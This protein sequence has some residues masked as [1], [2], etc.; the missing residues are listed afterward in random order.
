MRYQQKNK[1]KTAKKDSVDIN[2]RKKMGLTQAQFAALLNI[3]RAQLT[4]FES[5]KRSLDSAS[6]ALLADIQL[7]F[8]ELETGNL[9]AYR[10]L[11]TRLFL[12][13]EYKKA[14]PQMQALEKEF[15]QT[16]KE[17]KNDLEAMKQQAKDREHTIIIFTRYVNKLTEEG[18][19]DKKTLQQIVGFNLFKQQAY[20][21]LL[22]YWEPEQAK[23]H[24]RIEAL[25]GEARALRRYRMKIMRAHNPLKK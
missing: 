10:S 2:L 13:E 9:A 11:E 18:K 7:Q 15:R 17:M 24:A 5:G 16:I 22:T 23:L 19:Q 1:R 12:N 4:R 21:Q 8:R 14:L 20:T 3:S 6:S 25:A